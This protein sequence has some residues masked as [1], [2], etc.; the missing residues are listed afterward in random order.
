MIQVKI[1]ALSGLELAEKIVKYCQDYHPAGHGT[2]VKAI[3]RDSLGRWCAT[4][5]RGASCD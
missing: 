3:T 5:E 4:I 2:C 1:Y